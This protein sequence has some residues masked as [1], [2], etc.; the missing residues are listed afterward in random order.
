MVVVVVGK[1]TPEG[2]VVADTDTAGEEEVEE[3]VDPSA[4]RN[5]GGGNS[6]SGAFG[7]RC[8]FG[9]MKKVEEEPRI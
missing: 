5:V 6:N 7:W 2:A 1:M 8:S 4:E 9:D 3:V